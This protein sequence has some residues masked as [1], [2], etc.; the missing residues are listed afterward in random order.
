MKPYLISLLLLLLPPGPKAATALPL[1]DHQLEVE[2]LPERSSLEVSDR[3]ELAEAAREVEFHLHAG[4]SPRLVDPQATL[5]LLSRQQGLVPS[6]HYRVRFAQPT[7]RFTLRYGGRIH[8]PLSGQDGG[9]GGTPGIISQ[10]GVYLTASSLWFPWLENHLL[11][12]TLKVK[13]PAGW[14]SLSQG[15]ALAQDRGW[16]AEVPQDDLYLLAGRWHHY[17]HP[18]AIARAEVYLRQADPALAQRYLRA[19]DHYLQLF[20]R[21]I[22]PYPYPK[23]ALVENFWESGYGMPSF[24]LLGPRVIRLPFILYSSYPHEILHNWWGNGVYVDYAGGNWS[25]GLTSYL[26]D[27][28]IREQQGRGAQ[29]RRDTLEQYANWVREGRDVP[30]VRFRSRHGEASQ[31]AGYGRMLMFMHMLR[32]QLGDTA[33]LEGVRRFYRDNRFRIAGFADLKAAFETASGRNLN[34]EFSQW[35]TRTG[36]PALRLTQVRLERQGASYRLSAKLRQTQKAPPFKLRIPLYLQFDDEVRQHWLNMTDRELTVELTTDQQPLRLLVDPLF[37]LF[38]RLDPDESPPSL[39]SLFAAEKL[40]LILPAAD[41]LKA[42]YLRLAR[43]WQQRYSQATLHW[44]DEIDALPA[45]GASWIFGSGNRFAKQALDSLQPQ[46]VGLSA[47]RFQLGEQKYRLRGNSLVLAGRAKQPLGLLILGLAAA[48][49]ALAR[50][51]PHYGKYGYL[52]F[53]GDQAENRLKGQWQ[54]L[55]SGLTATL[56]NGRALPPLQLSD[57]PPLA[58][59]GQQ[60]QASR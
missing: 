24:T 28:L 27:H 33:F 56:V 58:G 5:T 47:D 32:L 59:T 14:R 35:T 23:F 10:D 20:S 8:H 55:A 34:Q 50:K 1:V 12:F 51:L 39:A 41:P 11:T 60:S 15:A 21:L 40:H 7:R 31:A 53:A 48:A 43:Q 9:R 13:L 29:Y 57:H 36:A 49:P 18:G 44:D 3:I 16:R 25:E 30:L 6:E 2:L 52:L 19:T 26:A 54:T 38:R 45:G 37:D 46:G 17:Q 42:A 22:G 4:L